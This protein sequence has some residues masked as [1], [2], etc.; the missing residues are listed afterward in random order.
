MIPP[1]AR[2]PGRR[3]G[4]PPGTVTVGI[5]AFAAVEL[6]LAVFMAVAPHAF[7]RAVGPFGPFNGHYVRDVASFEA[8]LGAGLLVALRRPAWRVPMLGVMTIQYALHSVNHLI[9]I[10]RAHPAWLGYFDFISL[11]AATLMLAWLWRAAAREAGAGE[12]TPRDPAQ[13]GVPRAAASTGA[14]AASAA[15]AGRGG[16]R[17]PTTEGSVT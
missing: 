2:S 8:A 1:A 10:D 3:S 5:A 13:A 9:D 7:Y 16:D 12:G 17:L 4:P 15:G 11:A 14:P 6:A